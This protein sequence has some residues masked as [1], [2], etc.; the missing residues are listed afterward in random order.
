MNLV[1]HSI[2]WVR[3]EIFEM[4]LISVAGIALIA[5]GIAFWKFGATPLAK[6]MLELHDSRMEI[7]SDPGSGTRIVLRFP[8]NRIVGGQQVAAA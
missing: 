7:S 2:N 3:G 1:Q 6:A 5:A 8:A 4:V